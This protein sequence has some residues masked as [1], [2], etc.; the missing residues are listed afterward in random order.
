MASSGQPRVRQRNRRGDGQRLREDLVAAGAAM[1]AES[2]DSEG[3]TLR[4]LA[5]RVGV[6][7]P[8]IYQHF[9]DVEELKDAV[10]AHTFAAFSSARDAASRDLTDP[11][12]ALLARC[13]VYCEFALDHPGAYRFLFR[14]RSPAAAG[15]LVGGPALTALAD[16]IASC[17]ATGV[18]SAGD[19][20]RLAT[21]VWAALHGLVLLRMNL[22]HFPWPAPL[23][24]MAQD[25]VT[26]L[27]D[28]PSHHA[29]DIRGRSRP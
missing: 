21:Q 15:P 26:R 4:G 23:T 8:S 14:P 27:L 20:I 2:G 10:A 13:Q 7:A 12:T 5:R 1:V 16:S 18:A 22:T 3:L 24:D 19:S 9:A 29:D 25:T 17:Q 6:A 11:V 28:L